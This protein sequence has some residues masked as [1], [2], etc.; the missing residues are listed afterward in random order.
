M[1][2]N[3]G[4]WVF[5]AHCMASPVAPL[6]FRKSIRWLRLFAKLTCAVLPSTVCDGIE[7]K[8]DP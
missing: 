7:P 5:N 8:F 3:L 2:W 4:N 1:K 6:V